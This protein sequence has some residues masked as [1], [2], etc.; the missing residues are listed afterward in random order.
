MG[1]FVCLF[2][3][4]VSWSNRAKEGQISLTPNQKPNVVT[5]PKCSELVQFQIG[6]LLAL[7]M[8]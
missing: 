7:E 4:A 8:K 5:G 1:I 3:S 6:A 2:L